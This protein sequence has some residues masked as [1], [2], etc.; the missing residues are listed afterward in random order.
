MVAEG[1]LPK[2]FYGINTA[3]RGCR[4]CARHD[5]IAATA[6]KTCYFNAYGVMPAN[7]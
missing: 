6:L 1:P 3:K 2:P 4:A 5:A 7:E